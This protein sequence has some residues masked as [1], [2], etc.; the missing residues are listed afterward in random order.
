MVPKK[1]PVE[2]GVEI[3]R[4]V[5]A[6]LEL[7]ALGEWPFYKHHPLSDWPGCP[8]HL[9]PKLDHQT[10]LEGSALGLGP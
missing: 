3:S 7:L 6:G 2:A 4:V 5:G 10:K 1:V 8:G 9:I